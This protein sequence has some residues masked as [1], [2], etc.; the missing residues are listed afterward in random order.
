MSPLNWVRSYHHEQEFS[1]IGFYND[2]PVLAPLSRFD[3]EP[4]I[5]KVVVKRGRGGPTTTSLAAGQASQASRELFPDLHWLEH[6]RIR[7]VLEHV[8]YSPVHVR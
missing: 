3:H 5:D 6:L 1:G 4:A 8:P 7:P 2:F